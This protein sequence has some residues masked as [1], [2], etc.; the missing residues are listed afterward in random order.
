MMTRVSKQ[1]RMKETINTQSCRITTTGSF[2]SLEFESSGFL[3]CI[4]NI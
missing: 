1:S 3:S 4:Q 2:L